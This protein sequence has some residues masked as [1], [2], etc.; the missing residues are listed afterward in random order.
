ME[1]SQWL[2]SLLGS[3]GSLLESIGG[4]APL[5]GLIGFS[6]AILLGWLIGHSRGQRDITRLR[7]ANVR[8]N[9]LLEYERTACEEKTHVLEHCAGFHLILLVTSFFLIC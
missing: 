2:D 8:L 3:T 4:S 5:T 1:I 7:E 6:L 9:T